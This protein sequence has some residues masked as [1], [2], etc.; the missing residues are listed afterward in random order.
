MN[1]QLPAGV[2]GTTLLIWIALIT[3]I[4]FRASRP[5]KIS[6]VRMWVSPILLM[7]LAGFAM[8]ATERLHPTPLWQVAIAVIAGLAAGIPLGALRGR[9][10]EVHTTEKHGVMRMGASWATALLYVGAFALRFAIRL[11]VPLTS[12]AGTAVGDGLLAFAIAIIAATYFVVYRKYQMLDHA[13]TGATAA[14][15]NSRLD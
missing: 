12:P 3:L 10:T 15:P 14:S 9:H 8:Y 5:Q 6:V 11:V 7:A 13:L 2:T 1:A 4:V